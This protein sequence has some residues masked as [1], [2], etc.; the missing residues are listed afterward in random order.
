MQSTNCLISYM[1]MNSLD[2]LSTWLCLS[3]ITILIQFND[4]FFF[5]TTRWNCQ[6]ILG[7]L[8]FRANAKRFP[9]LTDL[10]VRSSGA[11]CQNSK[12]F[13]YKFVTQNNLVNNINASKISKAYRGK[14]H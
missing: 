1:L 4:L 13:K 6:D 2:E 3:Y 9:A 7:L 14:N 8:S 5:A 11:A 10:Q 12:A